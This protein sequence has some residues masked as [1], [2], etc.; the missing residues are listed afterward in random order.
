MAAQ[1]FFREGL[2][3]KFRALFEKSTRLCKKSTLNNNRVENLFV[4]SV[5]RNAQFFTFFFINLIN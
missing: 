4:L 3:A 5:E 1:H 2:V